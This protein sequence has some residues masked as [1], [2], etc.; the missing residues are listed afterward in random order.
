MKWSSSV[1]YSIYIFPGSFPPFVFEMI[2]RVFDK[3]R[4][5][6]A[7]THNACRSFCMFMRRGAFLLCLIHAISSTEGSFHQC[8]RHMSCISHPSASLSSSFSFYFPVPFLFIACLV[9]E[10]C[11]ILFLCYTPSHR[12]MNHAWLLV[13]GFVLKGY[14]YASQ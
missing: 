6:I 13:A 1:V 10:V 11:M 9:I 5:I 4:L 2:S 7:C 14:L 3:G 8:T 12:P